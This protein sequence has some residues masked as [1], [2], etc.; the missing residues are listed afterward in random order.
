MIKKFQASNNIYP[1]ALKYN[2]STIVTYLKTPNTTVHVSHHA[3]P[4]KRYYNLVAGLFLYCK[5]EKTTA[6]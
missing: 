3:H 5:I 6:V 2:P 4:S 1:R